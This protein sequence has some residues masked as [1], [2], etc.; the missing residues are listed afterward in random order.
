MPTPEEF[1]AMNPE[2]ECACG[3]PLSMHLTIGARWCLRGDCG[4]SGFTTPAEME[5]IRKTIAIKTTERKEEGRGK[6][7]SKNDEPVSKKKILAIVGASILALSGVAKLVKDNT[8]ERHAVI[9]AANERYT[10]YLTQSNISLQIL[11]REVLA[12][13]E[14]IK[15]AEITWP[16]TRLRGCHQSKY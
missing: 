13:N 12:T 3:D 1:A 4:C 14:K 11:Y 10:N 6:N 15:K 5:E 9:V 2:S 7:C 8:V 16:G